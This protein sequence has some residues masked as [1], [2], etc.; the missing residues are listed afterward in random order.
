MCLKATSSLPHPLVVRPQKGEARIPIPGH[1]HAGAEQR[2]Y[3]E[4][5]GQNNKH[6]PTVLA[7]DKSGTGKIS[8]LGAQFGERGYDHTRTHTYKGFYKPAPTPLPASPLHTPS[9]SCPSHRS[10]HHI[11]SLGESAERWDPSGDSWKCHLPT[12]RVRH[13][14]PLCCTLHTHTHTHTHTHI[15]S[16]A[17][18]LSLSPAMTV[19]RPARCFQSPM[20]RRAPDTRHLPLHTLPPPP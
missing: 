18:S 5:Q 20:S 3:S 2:E 13:P 12:P 8:G 1:P 11:L 4:L 16:L 7:G 15:H 10:H 19:I 9:T 14:H 17:L 6:C